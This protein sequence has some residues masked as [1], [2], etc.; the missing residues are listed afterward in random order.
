MYDVK[1]RYTVSAVT[2]KLGVTCH[3]IAAI[4]IITAILADLSQVATAIYAMS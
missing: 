4:I 1:I 2:P 3:E